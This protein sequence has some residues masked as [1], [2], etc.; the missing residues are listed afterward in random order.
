M[1]HEFNDY[2][3]LIKRCTSKELDIPFYIISPS[4]LR[5]IPYEAAV[6]I[7]GDFFV[8]PRE[9]LFF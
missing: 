6:A 3:A 7:S 2:A 9:Y 1:L 8:L 4:S 5:F